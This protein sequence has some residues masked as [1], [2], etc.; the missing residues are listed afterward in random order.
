[1]RHIGVNVLSGDDFCTFD[2]FGYL[3]WY[4]ARVFADLIPPFFF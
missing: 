2:M 3:V 1:M 4:A